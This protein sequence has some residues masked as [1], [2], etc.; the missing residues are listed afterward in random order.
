MNKGCFKKGHVPWNKGVKGLHLNSLTEFKKGQF[1]MDKHP[2]WKGGM[3]K[4]KHDCVY[5][6]VESNKKIRRPKK[7]YEDVHGLIPNNWVIYHLDGD[8]HNDEI[9]NLIAI[10][11]SVLLKL[12][13]GEIGN[14]YYEIRKAIETMKK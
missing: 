7:V 12:N 8:R 10:P 1:V 3:H 13:N 6:L 2:S 14:S 4:M 11:R 9:D 5:I